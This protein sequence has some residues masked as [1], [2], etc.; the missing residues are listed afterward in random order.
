MLSATA[1]ELTLSRPPARASPAARLTDELREY[2]RVEIEPAPAAVPRVSVTALGF[3]RVASPTR[4]LPL[5]AAFAAVPWGSFASHG[6]QSRMSVWFVPIPPDALGRV[7]GALVL[8]GHC[9]QLGFDLR[10]LIRFAA[11]ST[12][13][14]RRV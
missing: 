13:R 8:V 11:Q 3:H 7:R 5:A 1:Q 14:S 2:N 10:Y 4:V 12:W 6:F 9:R